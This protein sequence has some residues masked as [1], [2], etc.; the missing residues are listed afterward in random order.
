MRIRYGYRRIHVLL[1]REGWPVNHKRVRRL[2]REEGLN[3]RTKRPRR[4]VMAA[5]RVERRL[6]QRPNEIWAMELPPCGRCLRPV[7]DALFNGKRFRA[8][9]VVDAYT[10]ECLAIHAD[11]GI[12]GEQVVD[13]MDRLLFERGSAPANIRVDNGPEFIS[14]AL[15][16]WAYINRVTLELASPPFGSA[17]PASLRTMH[18]LDRS[19]GGSGTNARTRIGSCLWTTPGPNSQRDDGTSTRPGLT[20]HWGS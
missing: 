5:R 10:R 14:Q 15:D 17:G 8:L 3:L 13:V 11:Q 20:H 16:Q 18:S 7:S 12:K 6:A 4:Y 1:R 2:Y 9:T 19:M